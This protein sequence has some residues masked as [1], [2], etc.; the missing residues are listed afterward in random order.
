MTSKRLYVGNISSSVTDTDIEQLFSKFGKVCAVDIRSKTVDDKSKC[1]AFVD[2]EIDDASVPRV[3]KRL[4]CTKWKGQEISIQVAKESFMDRL[5]KEREESRE[6]MNNNSKPV[7]PAFPI[8]R[9]QNNR[10]EHRQMSKITKFDDVPDV[11]SAEQQTLIKAALVSGKQLN[12]R[13]VFD[14]STETNT[15]KKKK[16]FNDDDDTEELS[17]DTSFQ[18]KLGKKKKSVLGKSISRKPRV[19]DDKKS[20]K[21]SLLIPRFDPSKLSDTEK[22][23]L[24]AKNNSPEKD[25]RS[26]EIDENEKAEEQQS[27]VSKERY[28]EVSSS[29]KDIWKRKE[30]EPQNSFSISQ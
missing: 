5:K 18:D 30:D 21:S 2:L 15:E 12:K 13:V 7:K 25:K 29:L 20:L 10:I 17:I 27:E 22:Y 16:L 26:D 6:S 1:F 4:N 28:Y 19:S 14:N 9:A 8:K 11:S 23:E 3:I 24:K